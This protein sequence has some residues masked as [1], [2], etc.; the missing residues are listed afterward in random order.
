MDI[1]ELQT[2]VEVADA[3]GYFTGGAAARRVEVD[4]HNG[5]ALAAATAGL[6]VAYLPDCLTH[7]HIAIGAL[8][9]IMTNHPPPPAGAYLIRPPGAHPARKIRVLTE[10]LI[11]YFSES[12]H[13][14]VLPI[15]H[16][17]QTLACETGSA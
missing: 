3:G 5:T 10:L 1:E 16:Q 7:E 13:L 12:P 2:F 9:P 15:S 4:R 8:V 11:E 17:E 14:A 6:G